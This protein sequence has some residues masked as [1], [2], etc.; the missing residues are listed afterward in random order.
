MKSKLNYLSIVIFLF[1]TMMPA[2]C[3]SQT[4]ET[5]KRKLMSEM[6]TFFPWVFVDTI[7]IKN[8]IILNIDNIGYLTDESVLDW[9]NPKVVTS[10]P[11]TF[12]TTVH[13]WSTK[14]IDYW[15][16]EM[17][18]WRSPQYASLF[19]TS[20]VSDEFGT[21]YE[22]NYIGKK[23]GVEIYKAEGENLLVAFFLVRVW[24]LNKSL[25]PLIEFKDKVDPNY[26][27]REIKTR[28]KGMEYIQVAYPL[29][30]L[31]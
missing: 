21:V 17:G 12:V 2:E 24:N 3:F 22:F 5:E 28:F 4:N 25:N 23:K 27:H 9:D 1:M 8:P 26:K 30:R 31:E 29:K 16:Q 10:Y 14:V 19:K 13:I 11:Q 7:N 20:N 6:D 18:P 15:G